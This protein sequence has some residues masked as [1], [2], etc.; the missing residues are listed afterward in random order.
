[1]QGFWKTLEA[2]GAILFIAAP[3]WLKNVWGL[4]SS[5]P[6]VP[7]IAKKLPER[8]RQVSWLKFSPY[9]V[10]MPVG[11]LFL[12]IILLN[13]LPTPITG[14]PTNFQTGPTQA[15]SGGAVFSGTF[16]FNGGNN[17]VG[18]GNTMNVTNITVT[19]GAQT[20]QASVSFSDEVQNQPKD[21]NF[22]TE[23]TAHV[24]SPFPVRLL[25]VFAGG[26]HLIKPTSAQEAI[27][28]MPMLNG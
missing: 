8:W 24:H 21:G 14:S 5:E 10:T 16:N 20:F 22:V 26:E 7:W 13:S 23:I 3:Q 1:M 27:Y 4:F 19:N 18:T 9:W 6:L 2:V 15:G 28:L 12:I 11:V 25:T 17:Q